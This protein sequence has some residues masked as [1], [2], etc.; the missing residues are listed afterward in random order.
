M[1]QQGL[2]PDLLPAREDRV[3]EG[4]ENVEKVRRN[5]SIIETSIGPEQEDRQTT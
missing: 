2:I 4:P 1:Y 5:Q 3:K